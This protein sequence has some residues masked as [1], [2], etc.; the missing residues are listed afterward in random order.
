MILTPYGV[1]RRNL[2]FGPPCRWKTHWTK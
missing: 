2:L 1:K